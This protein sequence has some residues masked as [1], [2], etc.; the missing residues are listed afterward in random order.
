MKISFNKK[1][2]LAFLLGGVMFVVCRGAINSGEATKGTSDSLQVVSTDINS[3]NNTNVEIENVTNC[4]QFGNLTFSG[5]VNMF[6]QPGDIEAMLN[7]NLRRGNGI[8]QEIIGKICGGDLVKVYGI[9]DNGWYLV[10]YNGVL[11]FAHSDYFLNRTLAPEAVEY[12]KEIQKNMESNVVVQ[13]PNVVEDTLEEKTIYD[14]YPN[15]IPANGVMYANCNVHFRTGP[16]KDNE[17]ITLIKKGKEVKIFGIDNGWY[18]VEYNGK[19]G[20]V[21]SYHL[22][23][24]KD[25]QYRDDMLN[26]VYVTYSSPLL[27][28]PSDKS[29][30]KYYFSKYEVCEVLGMNDEWYYVRYEDMYGYLRR[31][32]TSN[33]GN[34][35]VVVDI[36]NQRLTL[37]ENNRIVVETD[38][39]TGTLGVFDTPTGM[40]YIKN[41]VTNTSL[42][43]EKYGYDQPV[44]Y[45]MPF[46]GGIG[47]H[48]ADWRSKFG[49][50]IYVKDG[51]HGCVNIP[52]KYADDVFDNV[53]YKTRVIV[54]R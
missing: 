16:S 39:V 17:S 13:N 22:S 24:N 41:K 48:D 23:Y 35:A 14:M 32:C 29:Y 5:S 20:Y 51:S 40:Y 15:I 10:S 28:A 34:K 42:K 38:V 1:R 7:V 53:D 9:S 49:G 47:L 46:N 6:F 43:S 8:D 30:A 37:Y 27:D 36:D 11:G 2:I 25:S 52:P 4:Q 44:D 21:Y 33:I 50:E 12:V 31:D 26:V 18:L 45:W 3:N 19:I 54:H